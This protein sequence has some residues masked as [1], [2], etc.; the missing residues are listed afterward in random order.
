[1][2]SNNQN[3]DLYRPVKGERWRKSDS[4]PSLAEEQGEMGEK[5]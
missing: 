2:E 3:E 5:I 4:A 1:M